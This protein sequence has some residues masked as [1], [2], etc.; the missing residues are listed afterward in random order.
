MQCLQCCFLE[1][2][3]EIPEN[4]RGILEGFQV[5]THPLAA[6]LKG[7]DNTTANWWLFL[8]V[9]SF[10]DT[11]YW[12]WLSSPLDLTKDCRETW[13]SPTDLWFRLPPSWQL[14]EAGITNAGR[15]PGS[16]LSLGRLWPTCGCQV[17]LGFVGG[18]KIILATLATLGPFL[19]GRI[20][21][22]L[23]IL[24]YHSWWVI[25]IMLLLAIT[26]WLAGKRWRRWRRDKKAINTLALVPL[27]FLCQFCTEKHSDFL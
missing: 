22:I 1:E 25:R 26:F 12:L 16:L 11:C 13:E 2:A 3:S 17:Q 21:P 14:M 20:H 7:V 18:L 27:R 5:I 4:D 10:V 23:Q 6:I 15:Y 9:L 8:N 19:A 24:M